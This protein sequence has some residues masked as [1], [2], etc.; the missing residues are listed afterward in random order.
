MKVYLLRINEERALFYSESSDT[1]INSPTETSSWI[2]RKYKELQTLLSEAESGIG[3]R[4]RRA[5]EWL[6]QLTPLDEDLLKSLRRAKSIEL[7]Y[8]ANL[9]EEDALASW[10]KYLN[11]R[12]R[13][14][15]LWAVINSIITPLTL[16]L[17]LLPGPN[18][19]GYWFAYR[20]ICHILII[21]GIKRAKEASVECHQTTSLE[22]SLEISLPDCVARAEQLAKTLGLKDLDS[23]IKRLINRPKRANYSKLVES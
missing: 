12:Y 17:A 22:D 15:M 3:L 18:I 16:A 23:Y 14:H 20:A 7:Y 6:H 5:W 19:I 21:C 11:N 8:P 4:M 10:N 2:W 1:S 9:T 13:Y